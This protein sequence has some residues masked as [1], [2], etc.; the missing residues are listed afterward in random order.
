[1]SEEVLMADGAIKRQG[2]SLAPQGVV[3]RVVRGGSNQTGVTVNTPTRVQLNSVVFDPYGWFDTSSYRFTP[4]IAG[5]YRV[6]GVVASG[7]TAAAGNYLLSILYK[8]GAEYQ[9]MSE[10]QFGGTTDAL[11]AVG[12][13][14]VYCNGTTDYLELWGQ[15]G[16]TSF[17]LTYTEFTAELIGTTVGVLPAPWQLL[18]LGAGWANNTSLGYA[19]AFM[20]NGPLVYLRGYVVPT[21]ARS[22][23]GVVLTLPT[24][25]RPTVLTRQPVLCSDGTNNGTGQLDID[26]TGDIKLWALYQEPWPS[27]ANQGWLSLDGVSFSL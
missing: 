14:L 6:S 10:V 18:T 5:Y 24:E 13:T 16:A 23:G 12:T 27:V 1:M 25:C 8:N 15:G 17:G 22:S 19:A 21:A 2:D 9:R 7:G 20:R 11:Q 3:C 4:K 26:V